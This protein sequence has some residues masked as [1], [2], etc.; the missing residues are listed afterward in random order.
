[1]FEGP[2]RRRPLRVRRGTLDVLSVSRQRGRL[3][4]LRHPTQGISLGRKGNVDKRDTPRAPIS[5]S[6]SCLFSQDFGLR[7][8]RVSVSSSGLSVFGPEQSPPSARSRLSPE[9]R[10]LRRPG[11]TRRRVKSRASQRNAKHN[12][13]LFLLALR[14]KGVP[15]QTPAPPEGEPRARCLAP[16]HRR[17]SG[18]VS[19]TPCSSKSDV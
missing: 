19:S 6:P 11:R 10:L 13:S 17:E 5:R 15:G 3:H 18:H 4:R 16:G 8:P 14:L 2:P 7:S 9:T 12:L 1:M